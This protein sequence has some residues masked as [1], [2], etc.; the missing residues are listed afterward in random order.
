MT[1]YSFPETTKRDKK[2]GRKMKYPY[3]RLSCPC[4]SAYALDSMFDYIKERGHP[5]AI[6]YD[7]LQKNDKYSLWR[8]GAEAVVD[9]SVS[10][11]EEA[12]GV[13]VKQANG[14]ERYV[15]KGNDNA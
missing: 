5:V 12:N 13:I 1:E 7:S 10:N 9:K 14:F 11:N 15:N 6:I 3:F 8:V 4:S 2:G